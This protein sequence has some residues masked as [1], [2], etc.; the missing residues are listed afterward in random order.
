MS[1]LT[2]EKAVYQ[3]PDESHEC[4]APDTPPG[5]G[6]HEKDPDR[7]RALTLPTTKPRRSLRTTPAIDAAEVM[8]GSCAICSNAV[9]GRP[10][11]TAVLAGGLT[12]SRVAI[13]ERVA[14]QP[15]A[16]SSATWLSRQRVHSPPA[17]A[18][19]KRHRKVVRVRVRPG[20]GRLVVDGDS[21]QHPSRKCEQPVCR[22][23]P[24]TKVRLTRRACSSRPD[25]RP[26]ARK[27]ASQ[28]KQW[29]D[30]RRQNR[31]ASMLLPAQWTL[32]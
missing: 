12:Q 14:L 24:D 6:Q 4:H 21:Q 25:D 31:C 17:A 2:M 19:P 9:G 11:G 23:H 27:P 30:R 1:Y 13:A 32:R 10:D 18:V 29:W 15:A 8:A 7:H 16:P 3:S 20:Q 5:S 22:E 28:H 26:P